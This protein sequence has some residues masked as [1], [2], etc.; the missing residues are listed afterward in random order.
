MKS[1]SREIAKK[2]GIAGWD[3]PTIDALELLKNWLESEKSGRW[4]LVYDNVDDVDLMYGKERGC[5]SAYFPRSDRGS[6]IITTRS[7]QVGIKFA[8]AKGIVPLFAL[9]V[10]ESVALVAAKLG[11]SDSEASSRT[12]L[13]ETLEGIPL[14]L[15]Q[16]TSFIQEND[17]TVDRYLELYEA[18]DASKIQ[19]LSEDFEDHTRDSDLRNPIAATWVVT[20]EYLRGYQPLAADTLCMMSNFDTQAIPETFVSRVAEGNPPSPVNAEKALGLLQA[21]SLIILR[22]EA[23][24]TPS[25]AGRMF[26][27]HR[28][29]R[30]TTRNWL[31]MR[32]TYD[33]WV[34]QAIDMMSVKYDELKGATYDTIWRTKSNYLPHALTLLNSPQLQLLNE[35]ISVP[36][37]FENQ[38]LQDDHAVKG[39]ICPSCTANILSEMLSR[40]KSWLQ[41]LRM[42]RKAIA[43]TSKTLGPSHMV[44]LDHR[45]SEARGSWRLEE[46]A[47][48][49]LA[50]REV[51]ASY[52]A[53]LGQRHVKTLRTGRFLADALNDQGMYEEAERIL[54]Q[55]IDTAKQEFGRDHV[56]TIE[57][58]QSLSTNLALQGRLQETKALNLSISKLNLDLESR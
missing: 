53:V 57:A 51:L 30:L 8:T 43:I 34:A 1:G 55:V 29:V 35:G 52:S 37:V 44:T 45:Y 18:S 47:R 25:S 7:K 48:P 28:L 16:A 21:Y 42:T 26:S 9:T 24:S 12:K 33:Y 38:V 10:A 4:L 40:N 54:H 3:D 39:K 5:L 32:S 17:S 2:V 31:I 27:L 14:A 56:L 11:N 15:V 46:V 20:F 23:N 6:I 36:K 58:M 19:L 41:K 50:F 13:A 22:E 49:D